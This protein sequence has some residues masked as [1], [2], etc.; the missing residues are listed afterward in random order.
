MLDRVSRA[1]RA[2]GYAA[3]VMLGRM[4]YVQFW[5]PEVGSQR[6]VTPKS[7]TSMIPSQK[8][9]SDWPSTARVVPA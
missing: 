8:L 5:N 2:V 6:S 4:R 9:G 3:R 1:T 7:R